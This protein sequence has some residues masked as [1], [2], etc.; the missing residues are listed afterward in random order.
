MSIALAL[1]ETSRDAPILLLRGRVALDSEMA[2][3]KIL[4][5]SRLRRSPVS[6][7][8]K[9]RLSDISHDDIEGYLTA[10][11]LFPLSSIE[12]ETAICVEPPL[13]K[14]VRLIG[15]RAGREA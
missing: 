5:A 3:S 11:G 15:H 6:R 9:R 13:P 4:F 10:L 1:S 8:I 12:A 7:L 14:K 2:P